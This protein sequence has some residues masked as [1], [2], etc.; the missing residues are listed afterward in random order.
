MLHITESK[1]RGLQ[2]SI[3]AGNVAEAI[4]LDALLTS[5]GIMFVKSQSDPW[6]IQFKVE[7]ADTG[8][9]I[10]LLQ[11]WYTSMGDLQHGI[12]TRHHTA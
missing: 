4:I 7:A 8:T 6:Y 2:F 12:D 5:A 10:S 11:I 1:S 9:V 3:D